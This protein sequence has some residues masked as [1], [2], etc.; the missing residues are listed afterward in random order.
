MQIRVAAESDIPSILFL[1]AQL[2][3]NKEAT[4]SLP[5]AMEIFQRIE[6]YPNYHIYVAERHGEVVG[7]FSLAIMDNLAHNGAKSGL[8]EDVVVEEK[9]RNM[10][11]GK[12]MMLYAME[13]CKQNFCYK[14]CL[15]SNLKRDNTHR[16]YESLG[17]Q[18][19]G[20]SFQ[21]ILDF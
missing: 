4:V 7:T 1:Y 5:G 17:F 16:F 13:L 20:F 15:S 2:E 6:S 21:V 8:V 18:K 19:H 10:G 9:L 11:I 3:Q 12:E 14:V